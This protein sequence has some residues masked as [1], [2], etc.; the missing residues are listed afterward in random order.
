MGEGS[1]Q[2]SL[3][4]EFFWSLAH[5]TPLYV[6]PHLHL[7]HG[8]VTNNGFHGGLFKNNKFKKKKKLLCAFVCL[9]WFKETGGLHSVQHW[10]QGFS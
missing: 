7:A 2:Q 1:Y 10:F 4:G 6:E 5:D 9:S 8:L 3:F